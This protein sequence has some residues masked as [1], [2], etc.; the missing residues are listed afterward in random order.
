MIGGS[1]SFT[2]LAS[3]I[4]LLCFGQDDADAAKKAT[5]IRGLMEVTGRGTM[6]TGVVAK[7]A[8]HEMTRMVEE[9]KKTLGPEFGDFWNEYPKDIKDQ[10]IVDMIVPVYA[11][12]FETAEVEELVRFH[13]SPIGQKMIRTMPLIGRE[14]LALGAESGKAL[15]NKAVEAFRARK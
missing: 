15:V 5:A 9:L 11:R 6:G 10:D 2:L 1:R 3:G 4:A 7:T 13:K 12:H 8:A 14:S